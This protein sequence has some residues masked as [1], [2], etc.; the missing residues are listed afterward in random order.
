[1]SYDD[2]KLDNPYSER[3]EREPD[4][5]A[6]FEQRREAEHFRKIADYHDFM[7]YLIRNEFDK[8]SNDRAKFIIQMAI[9][10][11]YRELAA[12]MER[13]SQ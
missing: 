3:Y 2:Y 9:Y 12:E 8:A 5:D 11:G 13:D 4:Y 1:M 7:Q 10:F 6:I